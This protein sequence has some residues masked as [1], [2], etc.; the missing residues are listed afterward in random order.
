LI[1]QNL[2]SFMLMTHDWCHIFLEQ[3]CLWGFFGAYRKKID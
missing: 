1:S 3:W 2:L